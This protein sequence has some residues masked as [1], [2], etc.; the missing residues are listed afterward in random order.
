MRQM[1]MPR[2]DGMLVSFAMQ[3]QKVVGSEQFSQRMVQEIT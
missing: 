1:S 3:M 2:W